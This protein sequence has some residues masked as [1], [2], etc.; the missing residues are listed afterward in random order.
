MWGEDR[1]SR[2][3]PEFACR[4]VVGALIRGFPVQQAAARIECADVARQLRTPEA[5]ACRTGAC[6]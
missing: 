1:Q 4:A 5:H 6:S 2:Y 3:R